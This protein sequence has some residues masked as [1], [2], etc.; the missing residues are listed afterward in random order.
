METIYIMIL[1]FLALLFYLDYREKNHKNNIKENFDSNNESQTINNSENESSE[2]ESIND[3]LEPYC[4]KMDDSFNR[5]MNNP[6]AINLGKKQTNF[7]TNGLDPFLRCPQCF[8][9]FDCSNY[10]YEI[11]DVNQT[12]CTTCID[13]NS[14]DYKV[15]GRQPGR[16]R[17]CQNLYN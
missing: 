1:I 16:P 17:N 11:S 5:T 10:P 13:K 8:M 15:L 9:N 4:N 12:L 7:T 6:N 3:N 2:N 14:D